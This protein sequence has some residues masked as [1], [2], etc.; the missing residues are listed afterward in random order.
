LSGDFN[1]SS[2]LP[3]S[4]TREQTP[5]TDVWLPGREMQFIN[6]WNI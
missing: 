2:K 1:A 5:D 3:L 6:Q 4:S